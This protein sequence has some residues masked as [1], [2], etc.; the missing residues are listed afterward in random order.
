MPTETLYGNSVSNATNLNNTANVTG[1]TPT[2]YADAADNNTNTTINIQF[3]TPTGNP[4]TGAGV[5]SITVYSSKIAGQT[6]DPL[7]SIEVWEEGG[8]AAIA[9]NSATITSTNKS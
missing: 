6:G 1:N 2:T 9:S 3:P 7:L 8:V 5:Q 4:T